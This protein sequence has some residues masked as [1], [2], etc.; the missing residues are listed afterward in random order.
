MHIWA[1]DEPDP[2]YIR[3]QCIY[4]RCTTFLPAG[5]PQEECLRQLEERITAKCR[6]AKGDDQD[7]M[8]EIVINVPEAESPMPDTAPLL[9]DDSP[10]EEQADPPPDEVRP[11]VA[12]LR[13]PP[14]G[15]G[16]AKNR[17]IF[18]VGYP[19][20]VGGA[21]TEVWHTLLLW[22]AFGLDVRVIP[23]WR[24]EPAWRMQVDALGYQTYE[25]DPDHLHLVPGLEGAIVVSFC[26]SAFLENVARFRKLGCR[27]VWANCMTWMFGKEK[28]H[29]Q[30]HG[31]FEAYM[32]QSEFQRSM[33]EPELAKFGYEP[34]QGHTI[35][36]AFDFR[37]WPFDPRQ[38]PPRS[39]FVVGRVARPDPDK[40]S[41][42]TWPIYERIQ[43]PRK[44]ALMMGIDDRV[45]KKL[46]PEPTWADCLKPG[47]LNTV[48]FFRQLHCL[49]PVNGGARENWPR[50]GLEAMACGVPI[51]AQKAWGWLE[52][53]EH[54]VTGFLGECDE[55]LA[56]YTAM[57]AW[58]EDLRLTIAR[59]ARKRLMDVLANPTVIWSGWKKLFLTL[60]EKPSQSAEDGSLVDTHPGT[61]GLLEAHVGADP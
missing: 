56:H 25:T 5:T 36:G 15:N 10:A 6:S 16:Q 41:S 57:L 51:V 31:T 38:H 33:L 26:N 12:D 14:S 50:A 42:N 45:R 58:D 39:P 40:W 60:D 4:C 47:A 49:L 17:K 37:Q 3:A 44:R 1:F 2:R 28:Q 13:R 61:P 22:K 18:L 11:T 27:I 55:E 9:E 43:Y 19:G 46:G 32:F 23:T 53:I 52:M 30:E 21:C 24:A 54:G 29:Y 20:D 7:T 8:Q 34:S 35:R 48:D 59:Q